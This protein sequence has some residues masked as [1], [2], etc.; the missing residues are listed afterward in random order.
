MLGALTASHNLLDHHPSLARYGINPFSVPALIA[1]TMS[2]VNLVWI[3]L[4]FR[5]T[6]SSESRADADVVRLRNPIRAIFALDNAPARRANLVAF[7]FSMAFVAMETSLTFLAAE[8]FGYTARQNGFLLGFLGL[9][10]VIMQGYIVR[11]VLR[12]TGEVRIL[13]VGLLISAAGLV[14]IGYAS[15]PGLLYAGLACLA[16]GSGLVNPVATGLISLYAGA[17]EQGRVLG[18]YRSLGALA[19][20]VTPI[21]AGLLYWAFHSEATYLVAAALA[22]V[23]AVLA[24]ALPRPHK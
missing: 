24:F 19:R 12:R 22:F 4:R 2:L 8:R 20:A 15:S 18:I 9:C 11:R 10:A 16:A 7:V 6:L 5:E 1:L 23:A 3:G 17:D 14:S 21:G 13:G